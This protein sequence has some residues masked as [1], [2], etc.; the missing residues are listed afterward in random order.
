[1]SKCKAC[2]R[3]LLISPN[4]P[5]RHLGEVIKCGDFERKTLVR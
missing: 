2:N 3:K 1:M 5:G 4:A